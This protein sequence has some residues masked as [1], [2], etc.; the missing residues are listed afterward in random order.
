MDAGPGR[1]DR[2]AHGAF[3]A[4]GGVPKAVVYDYVPGHIIAVMCRSALCGR[5]AKASEIAWNAFLT[6]AT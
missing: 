4:I 1:L 3:A 2:L 5:A 6:A